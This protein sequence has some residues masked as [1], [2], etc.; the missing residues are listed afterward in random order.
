MNNSLNNELKLIVNPDIRN[1][2]KA[3]LEKAPEYFWSIP[4]SSTGKHHPVDD[5][6]VGGLIIHTKKVTKLADDLCRNYNII[7]DERDC[8]IAAAIM[9]DLTKN[10]FPN[11]C[12]HTVNGHGSLWI[13]I[14]IQVVEPNVIH[15]VEYIKIIG[16]LISCHMGRWEIPYINN[17]DVLSNIL[18]VS[19]YIASRK[20]VKVDIS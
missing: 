10:G 12:G 4:S 17:G 13:N 2:V 3:C 8:V 14:A 11:D 20:Y 19:D 9:H 6:V 18:Q 5:N 15:G 7:S 1:F 16:R